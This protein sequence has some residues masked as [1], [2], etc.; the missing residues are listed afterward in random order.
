MTPN[1]L[2]KF[3]TKKTKQAD[4]ARLTGVSEATISRYIS[5]K[6]PI[7]NKFVISLTNAIALRKVTE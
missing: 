7:P 2:K 4:L 6:L 3:I 1:Q 5:G